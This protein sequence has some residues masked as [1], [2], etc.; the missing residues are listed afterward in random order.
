MAGSRILSNDST[1]QTIESALIG[2][3]AQRAVRQGVVDNPADVVVRDI[4]PL[5]DLAT[6]TTGAITSTYGFTSE[7]WRVDLRTYQQDGSTA[8]SAN[9]YNLVVK[10]NLNKEKVVGFAGVRKLGEDMVSAIRWSLGSGAK[11][12]D[13]WQID[14]LPEDGGVMYAE[15]PIIFNSSNVVKMEYYLKSP[16]ISFL[17]LIGKTAE[18][19]SDTIVGTE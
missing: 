18:A 3:L 11:I 16:G 9:A 8:S 15:N 19:R 13:I 2:E 1:K 17:Q 7:N 5:T 12:K 4:L 14:Y 6:G 10:V